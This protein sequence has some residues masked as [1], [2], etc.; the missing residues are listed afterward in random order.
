MST[1]PTLARRLNEWGLPL[2]VIGSVIGF[3]IGFAVGTH[4][5]P[6]SFGEDNSLGSDPGIL[7]GYALSVVG[8]LAGM[9]F[10]NYPIGRLFGAKRP[11]EE[12]NAYMHGEGGGLSTLLPD[13]H[14]PQGHRPAVPGDDPGLPVRRW[15]RRDVH[16]DRVAHAV[17]DGGA[18]PVVPHARRSAQH[19]DDLHGVGGDHRAVRQLLRADHDRHA[20]HG[21]PAPRG[22]DVLAPAAGRF[23]PALD[24]LPR[25]LHHRV[26]RLRAARRPERA[27]HGLVSHRLRADRVL[28]RTVRREHDRDDHHQARPGH[29]A[30]PDADLRLVGA[31][32]VVPRRARSA[33]AY[34]SGPDGDRSTARIRRRFFVP[35]GRWLPIPLG[36][37]VLVLRTSGGVHLRRAR[38]SGW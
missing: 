5:I 38:R 2:G 8:F 17:T 3:I 29:A 24:R 32:H 35:G 10:L 20:E 6:Y 30:E 21:I 4:A 22:A 7:L 23:D 16:P 28:D 19:A 37:P 31:G 33:G 9:G 34:R 18:R 12:D 25:R 27:R 1:P 26:D 36:E 13:D 14:R 11:S 15:A